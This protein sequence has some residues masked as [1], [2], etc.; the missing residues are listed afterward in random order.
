MVAL[1]ELVFFRNAS[2]KFN[3]ND[4]PVLNAP[5]IEMTTT[6]LCFSSSD[7]KMSFSA[8]EFSLNV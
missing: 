2:K 7:S 8:L 4:F 1:L 3:R 6:F 5:V